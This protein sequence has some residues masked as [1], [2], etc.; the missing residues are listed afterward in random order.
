M[1]YTDFFSKKLNR[2]QA[3]CSWFLRLKTCCFLLV[4]CSLPVQAIK[5]HFPDEELSTESVLPFVEE[6]QMVLNRNVFLKFRAELGVGLGL[7]LDEPFYFPVYPTSILTFHLTEVHA[8]SISGTYFFPK[9]SSAGESLS[10]GKGLEGSG[11]TF[12]PLKAPYPQMEALFNYQYSPYYGKISLA[13][14]WVLNLSIYGFAG[15]GLMVM[16]QN[17]RLFSGNVGI[18][19][20]LYLNKW[21]GFRGELGVYGYYNGP[22]IAKMRLDDSVGKVQYQ[23]L[24]PHEKRSIINVRANIGVILLI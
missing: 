21:L 6:P 8:I 5:I 7:G 3:F 14:T 1:G 23:Q 19:Q 16:D 20:K 10:Q 9:R 2:F 15:L 4:F 11:K 18:G 24:K 13:K 22:S 17:D 12:D